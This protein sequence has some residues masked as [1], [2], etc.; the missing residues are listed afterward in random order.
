MI[1]ART[2][3]M[4]E[5]G[6]QTRTR[7]ARPGGRGGELV[8]KSLHKVLRTV[9]I[10]ANSR[11]NMAQTGSAGARTHSSFRHPR[12]RSRN[13]AYK[14]QLSPSPQTRR[15]ILFEWGL[16][17]TPTGGV[18]ELPG[19]VPGIPRK[20]FSVRQGGV[21]N[22]TSAPLGDWQWRRDQFR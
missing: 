9:Y 11:N 22:Q 2:N 12:G 13:N 4:G 14:C 10:F 19:R 20:F 7:G 6:I 8:H 18:H 16:F 3:V 5:D 1:V 15:R 17:V 21:G